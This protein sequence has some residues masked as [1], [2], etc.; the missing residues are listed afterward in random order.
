MH[1]LFDR[2][3]QYIRKTH[4]TVIACWLDAHYI[5]VELCFTQLS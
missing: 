1:L 5:E 4:E 2:V 3:D